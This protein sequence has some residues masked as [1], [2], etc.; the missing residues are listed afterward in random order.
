MEG[1]GPGLEDLRGAA[2]GACSPL[3]AGGGGGCGGGEGGGVG[4]TALETG[5]EAWEGGRVG[6]GEGGQKASCFQGDGW[7]VG[8]RPCD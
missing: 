7:L 4:S 8:G 1:T 3:A 2:G 6:E 5:E